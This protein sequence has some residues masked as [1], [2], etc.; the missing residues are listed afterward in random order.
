MRTLAGIL[1]VG[2]VSYAALL[3]LLYGVQD[4]LIYP[5]TRPLT[6]SPADRG[7]SYDEVR[8]RTDDG[9]RLHGWWIP[10]EGQE[11]GALLFCHGNAG[12]IS[13]RLDSIEQ[14]RRLGFSVL[15]FDYRGYG[16]SSGTPSEPGLYRDVNAAWQYL[17]DEEYAPDEIVVF[18]RSLGSGPAT[19]LAERYAP[20]ALILEAPFTSVP[21]VAARRFPF[22]P[23][24]LLTRSRYNN[25]ARIA[26][27]ETPLLVIHSPDDRVIPFEHGRTLFEAAREPKTFLK[28]EGAHNDGFLVTGARYSRGID[29]FLRAHLDE[30]ERAEREREGAGE[31]K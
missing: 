31:R 30:P 13:G 29:R 5:G 16:R 2:G 21:D 11:R 7:W 6:A 15:I 22:V 23:A 1:A 20:G 9:E 17:L 26:R 19:W 12:N 4:H 8:L 25:H 27:I 14:F 18:G 24:R 3:A 28:I 10:A